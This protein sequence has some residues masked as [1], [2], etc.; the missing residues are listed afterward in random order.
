MANL[1]IPVGVPGSGK[2]TWAKSMLDLKYHIVSSDDI[3]M[4]LFGSLRAAHEPEVKKD[5]KAKVWATFYREI[6]DC[7]AHGVDVVADATNLRAFAREKLRDIAKL[8]HAQTHV[9]LFDNYYQA[10]F[11]NR[12]RPE[13]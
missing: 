12:E 9:L 11:R 3:R 7:L 6:D 13:D 2:S 4:R 5:D 8:Q 10:W 1:I